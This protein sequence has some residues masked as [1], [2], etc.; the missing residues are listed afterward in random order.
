MRNFIFSFSFLVFIVLNLSSAVFWILV[1]VVLTYIFIFIDVEAELSGPVS[2][3]YFCIIRKLSPIL[4]GGFSFVLYQIQ[5][6][7]CN[8]I[9]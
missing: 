4:E 6:F 2:V 5:I 8:E 9:F 7:Y 1:Q 3:Q